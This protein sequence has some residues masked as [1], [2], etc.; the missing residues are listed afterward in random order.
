MSG[1]DSVN[2][3]QERLESSA[4]GRQ[5]RCRRN[6]W[7]PCGSAIFRLRRLKVPGGH[8]TSQKRAGCTHEYGRPPR[9]CFA[10]RVKE[11]LVCSKVSNTPVKTPTEKR[12]SGAVRLACLPLQ[13]SESPS[14][15]VS[16]AACVAKDTVRC[17]CNCSVNKLPG[18]NYNLKSHE[19]MC[20]KTYQ[21]DTKSNPALTVQYYTARNN[22]HSTKY[23]HTS[24]VSRL[25]HIRDMLLHR[26]CD[27]RL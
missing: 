5:R 24:Y 26:L 8:G 7:R 23:S 27:F 25:I 18:V 1:Y 16:L 13:S 4:E 15:P 20:L 9:H 2:T 17:R 22:E 10:D 3:K 19:Y 14:L 11:M 12:H 21:P 6:L